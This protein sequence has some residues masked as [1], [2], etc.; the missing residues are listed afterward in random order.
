MDDAEEQSPTVIEEGSE[1]NRVDLIDE[2]S[3]GGGGGSDKSSSSNRIIDND[4]E[5]KAKKR[6][7]IDE[8]S[9][10]EL[11]KTTLKRAIRDTSESEGSSSDIG[12]DDLLNLKI[13]KKLTGREIL[14]MTYSDLMIK[15]IN[16]LN[17]PAM[18]LTAN[19]N[20]SLVLNS[21]LE[22]Y[23]RG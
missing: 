9:D 18:S 17:D 2:H 15:N 1:A 6:R 10:D 13:Y 11:E 23:F 14:N 12:L 19:C 21:N 5:K 7:S 8:D 20:Y 4:I 16:D 22:F 3:S